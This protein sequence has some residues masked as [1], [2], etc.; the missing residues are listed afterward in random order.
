MFT[1]KKQRKGW[2]YEQKKECPVNT[3][4]DW[5]NLLLVSP[6]KRKTDYS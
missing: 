6:R 2:G 1:G 5:I 3:P 4:E